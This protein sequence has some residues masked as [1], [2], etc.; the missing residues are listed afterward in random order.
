LVA[1][2]NFQGGKMFWREPIDYAQALVLYND[3]TWKAHQ[4]APFVEGS[5]EFSCPDSDTPSQCPP[6][7][8]RGFGLIWCDIP[9]VRNRLGN[10]TDCER[11]YQ[12]LMQEF[13]RGFMLTTD[14][15]S[16][17]VFYEDGQWERR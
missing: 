17:F 13:E 12:G 16:I 14:G 5:P 1:E 2:E 4:H 10:A 11:G 6:T 8:K 9:E 15:G 3:G 7:P